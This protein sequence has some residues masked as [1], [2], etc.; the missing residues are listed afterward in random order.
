MGISDQKRYVEE[1]EGEYDVRHKIT[2]Y[3]EKHVPHIHQQ[4][5]LLLV[6]SR[7]MACVI[8]GRHYALSPGT[9][10]LFNDMDL[11]LIRME[12]NCG[13]NDRHVLYFKPDFIRSLSTADTN[14]LECFLFRPFDDANILPLADGDA[15]RL[16]G[17]M[18]EL[19]ELTKSAPG[20][21]GRDLRVHLRI[22][23]LLLDVNLLY[24]AYH[25]MG[26]RSSVKRYDRVYEIIS[27]LHT[28]YQEELTLEE[29]AK[30]FYTN[31]YSLCA[32]FR[33]ATGSS[34][35]RY[36][37]QCRLQKAKELLIQGLSVEN[38][39]QQTGYNNLSHFSRAFKRFAGM[40]PKQFQQTM[41]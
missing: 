26:D 23:R 31:K 17:R 20:E 1:L 18:D 13:M 3:D 2:P 36:L 21:Y 28:H 9:L 35:N 41:R 6:H 32:L 30:R 33:E 24:R 14:L 19:I 7:G 11:H 5:E 10:L 37:I 15:E 12:N 16:S 29:L 22:A 4:F 8:N 38:V 27:Y 40:S 25:N 34:P 39:C